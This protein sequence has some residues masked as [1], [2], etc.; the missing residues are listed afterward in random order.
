MKCVYSLTLK[1]TH[2]SSAGL[3]T[4]LLSPSPKSLESWPFSRARPWLSFCTQHKS[5]A[6]GF[7]NE[8]NRT[9][10]R[11][12]ERPPLSISTGHGLN[13][14]RPPRLFRSLPAV[15][16][17]HIKADGPRLNSFAK[18]FFYVELLAELRERERG[19]Y[20]RREKNHGEKCF[21]CTKWYHR[22]RR[23][24]HV[25]RWLLLQPSGLFLCLV[26]CECVSPLV[27]L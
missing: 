17:H 20:E 10:T 27:I 1:F 5:K 12:L 21:G 18:F 8:L 24:D 25:P 4:S 2:S 9:F 11:Q 23:V 16:G 22:F 14:A 26:V 13:L 3:R 7:T 6:H 15:Q 19:K